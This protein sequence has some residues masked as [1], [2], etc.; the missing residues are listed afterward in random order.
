MEKIIHTL[1]AT[2]GLIV[3]APILHWLVQPLLER[4]RLYH[5]HSAFLFAFPTPEGELALH[6]GSLYDFATK[7][8][9]R[10]RGNEPWAVVLRR[11]IAEGIERFAQWLESNGVD[12]KRRVTM[13]SHFLNDRKMARVGFTATASSRLDAANVSLLYWELVVLQRIF[14]GRWHRIPVSRWK[15]YSCTVADFLANRAAIAASFGARVGAGENE[16]D[17]A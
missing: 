12:P 1:A 7:L 5:F 8:R 10:R 11:D 9:R 17:Q 16:R 6:L 2:I 14:T 4:T 13:G 3:A 15:T